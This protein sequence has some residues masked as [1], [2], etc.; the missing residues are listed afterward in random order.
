MAVIDGHWSSVGVGSANANVMGNN[1]DTKN[2]LIPDYVITPS[3]EDLL[4]DK[5]YS[6]EYTLKLIRENKVKN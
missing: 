3:L 1:N 2:G 5:D 6:L 4:C